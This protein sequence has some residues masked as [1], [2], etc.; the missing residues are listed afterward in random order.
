MGLWGRGYFLKWERSHP[1][2]ASPSQ[3]LRN[4]IVITLEQEPEFRQGVA[5]VN[6]LGHVPPPSDRWLFYAL[7]RALDIPGAS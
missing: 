1:P 4:V 5:S 7:G 2:V 6:Y 3:E